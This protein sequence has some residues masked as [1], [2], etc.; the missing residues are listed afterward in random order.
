MKW[1][2]ESSWSGGGSGDC[3]IRRYVI[4]ALRAAAEQHRPL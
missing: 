3:N 4:R 1:M 2:L